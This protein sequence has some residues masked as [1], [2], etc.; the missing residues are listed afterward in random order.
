MSLRFCAPVLLLL[1]S[2]PSHAQTDAEERFRGQNIR[3]PAGAG[4]VDVT[5]PPYNAVP[6]GVSHCTAAIQ[7]GPLLVKRLRIE[8]FQTGVSMRHAV[9]SV[10]F[11]HLEI[12]GSDV[13]VLNGGGQVVNM[14]KYR[15]EGP[16]VALRNEE[17]PGLVTLVDGEFK[18][19]WEAANRAAIENQA[20]LYARNLRSEGYPFTAGE[21]K[22]RRGAPFDSLV[23]IVRDGKETRLG[24]EDVQRRGHGSAVILFSTQTGE[25]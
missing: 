21:W 14:R 9:N 2:I 15:Y 20:G 8:G 10:T 7:Q 25:E 16:G 24:R 11:E 6:D 1:F 3:F 17:G 18:G 13:G 5:K 22:T 12:I 19:T 23:R 4:I